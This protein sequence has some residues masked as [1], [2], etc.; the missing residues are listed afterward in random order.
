M[1]HQKKEVIVNLS[2]CCAVLVGKNVDKKKTNEDGI[3]YPIIVGASDLVCGAFQPRRY[4][5]AKIKDV[6]YSEK[7]DILISVVGTIG[8]MGVNTTGRAI[9]SKHICALRIREGVSRQYIM[10][11]V[12]RL[13]LET[14]PAET[15][16]IVLGFQNKADVEKL[17]QLQFTLPPL[18]IQ[19]WI[20]SRLTSIAS[21]IFA[22]KG[23]KEDYLSCNR[24][25]DIIEQERKEQ[26]AHMRN[27]AAHLD[28]LASMLDNLPP[29]S[30]TLEMISDARSAYTRLLNIQ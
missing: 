28:K 14:I 18:F 25:I 15:E 6:V 12:S 16:E 21:M 4:T 29:D 24:I 22:Y 19:E 3:G 7:G 27:L 5:D 9:L 8:K 13:L 20:V 1:E 11:M 26:R 23:K 17:K 2:E 10:A 30:D